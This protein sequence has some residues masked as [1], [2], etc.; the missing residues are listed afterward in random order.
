MALITSSSPELELNL[1][2]SAGEGDE[3]VPVVDDSETSE[4]KLA[5]I[6]VLSILCVFG[7]IGNGLVL[8]VFNSKGN[9]VSYFAV[10]F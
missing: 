6:S 5:V 8:Y 1:T 10:L 7:T 9:K 4:Q 2:T 3:I